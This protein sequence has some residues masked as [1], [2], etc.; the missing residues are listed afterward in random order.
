MDEPTV[1]GFSRR[2]FL[3]GTSMLGA[4]TLLGLPRSAAAEPPPE[5]TKIR[6]VQSESICLAPQYR[7]GRVVAPGGICRGGIRQVLRWT[8]EQ[9]PRVGPGGFYDADRSRPDP[10]D[11]CG[12]TVV[13]ISGVHAGC[14]E[15]F[16]N[17]RIHSVRDLK[18]QRVAVSAIG[19]DDHI[20]HLQHHGLR[21]H[22][23]QNRHRVDYHQDAC[24]VDAHVRG[25]QGRRFPRISPSASGT[26]REEDRTR[27]RQHDTGPALVAVLLLHRCGAIVALLA[28]IPTPPNGHCAPS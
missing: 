27:H 25:K 14:Y 28:R 18:G 20:L 22:G 11:R 13:L 21:R 16:G 6:I 1:H 10:P 12:R 19:D 23:S 8:G 5:I 9:P 2:E 15:L 3:A 26:A 7:G 24:R 17:Q 4:A